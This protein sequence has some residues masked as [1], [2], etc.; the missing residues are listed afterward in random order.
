M[1]N[2][3]MHKTLALLTAAMTAV[4]LTGCG[5]GST[6]KGSTLE[7]S[8]ENSYSAQ[9]IR[10]DSFDVSRIFTAG[11]NLLFGGM[12]EDFNPR[13]SLYTTADGTLKDADFAYMK[14]A[15]DQRMIEP[16]GIF[17]KPDGSVCVL[18]NDYTVDENWEFVSQVYYLETYDSSLKLISGEDI[19][20]QFPEGVYFYEMVTDSS[21]TIYAMASDEEGNQYISVRDSSFAET[22]IVELS[23]EWIDSMFCSNDGNVYASGYSNMGGQVFG[24]ID[25]DTLLME[26]LSVEGMPDYYNGACAGSGDYDFYLYDSTSLYG[27]KAEEG[28][29]EEVVNWVNSDFSGDYVNSV[30]ALQD[31][32]FITSISDE[33]YE[34]STLWHMAE[35][36]AE[37]LENMEIISLAA[38]YSDMNL[39]NAVCT[40]NRSNDKLRIVVKDYSADVSDEDDYTVVLDNFKKDM[41]SG[42]VAD[43]ISLE[44]LNFES[45]ANKGM[46]VDLNTFMEQDEEF[47]KDDYFSSYFKTLEYKDQLQRIGF[48]FNVNTLAAKTEYVGEEMGITPAQFIELLKNTPNDMDAFPNM[49]KS[50]ALYSMCLGNISNFVDTDNATCSFNTPE[51]IEFLELCNTYPADDS[52]DY[53]SMTDDEWMLYWEAQEMAYRN[54]TALL[55]EI[56]IDSPETMHTLLMGDFGTQDVTFVGYPTADENSNGGIFMGDFTIAVSSQSKY[57]DEIWEFIKYMLSEEYQSSLSWTLPVHKGVFQQLADEA[58]N[59]KEEYDKY[60]YLGNEEI[61]IGYPTQEEMDRLTAYIESMTQSNF[62]DVSVYEVIF[63]EAEMFF[64]GDQTAQQTADMIQSRV[65]LYLS[66][67]S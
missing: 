27:I 18:Y 8:F 62:Y 42:K 44:G 15:S 36:S 65:S 61:E 63:E 59:S 56:Y 55:K 39:M 23:V 20:A 48:S 9:E 4:S 40:F 6:K 26:E 64:A 1:K 7:V 43:I 52:I 54:D 66:E 3:T 13:I 28:I 46:F 14:N 17:S 29:C 58:I 31:G 35:R 38:I 19:T 5:G 41:T 11:E 33:E 10:T 25:P 49:T 2:R 12:D 47:N 53:N 30:A 21:G 24:R 57:Q 37:E 67:Q 32:T 50:S 34:H 45:F 16:M 51:F 22:G 60:Y